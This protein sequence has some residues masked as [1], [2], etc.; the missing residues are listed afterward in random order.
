MYTDVDFQRKKAL[1][2]AVKAGQR[3]TVWQPGG[4][5]AAQ[6]DGAVVIEGPQY[7]KP[8]SWYASATIRD[9]VIVSVK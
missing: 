8:H 3:V 6:T 1:I 5:F 2:E 7:P 9:G 4:M